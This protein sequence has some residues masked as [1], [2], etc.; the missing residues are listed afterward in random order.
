MRAVPVIA[1]QPF[2]QIGGSLA[3]MAVGTPIRPFAQCGL[4]E[5]LGLAVGSRRVDLGEDV[6]QAPTPHS[7]GEGQRAIYLG[8]VSHDAAEPHAKV[9]VVARCMVEEC[10]C[11]TL[12]LVGEHLGK[13]HPRTIVD[14][15][16]RGFP[17]GAT[18]M[19]LRI[20]CHAV[21]DAL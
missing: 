9:A 20:A 17:A 4:D 15:H 3:G 10:R 13:A 8:V 18:G 7:R 2:W 21:P 16:K 19:I 12:A 5:A 14:G 11:T 1:M 6:S